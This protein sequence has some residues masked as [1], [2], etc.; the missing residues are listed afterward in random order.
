MDE[1]TITKSGDSGR[2]FICSNDFTH[3]AWMEL[4]GDFGGD[5][6]AKAF[7]ED[8]ARRLNATASTRA[9]Q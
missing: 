9:D 5:A 4:T 6:E 2:W 8:I 3:D 1:W 7:A